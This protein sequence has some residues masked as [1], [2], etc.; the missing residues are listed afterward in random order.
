MKSHRDKPNRPYEVEVPDAV[1]RILHNKFPGRLTDE[2][3]SFL[4]KDLRFDPDEFGPYGRRL[5]GSVE[6]KYSAKRRRF[7]VIYVIDDAAHKIK[8]VKIDPL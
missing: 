3:I 7:R 6:K 4:Q 8:V 2:V 5:S 1:G